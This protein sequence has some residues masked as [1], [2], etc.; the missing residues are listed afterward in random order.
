MRYTTLLLSVLLGCAS[1]AQEDDI[2]APAPGPVTVVEE[3][4]SEAA[5]APVEGFPSRPDLGHVLQRA[6]DVPLVVA[7]QAAVRRE[8]GGLRQ[9][10]LA[11][12][13]VLRM[14]V[15]QWD[16]DDLDGGPAR[17]WIRLHERFETGGK[18]GARKEVAEWRVREASANERWERFRVA[19]AAAAAH[20]EAAVYQERVRI[21]EQTL[22]TQ[23]ELVELK[24]AQVTSGREKE[25]VLIPLHAELG[26]LTVR[27]AQERAQVRAALRRLE[28]VLALPAGALDG[29]EGGLALI[30]RVLP[31]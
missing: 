28:G 1:S 21:G 7:A 25:A 31:A 14:S 13:P 29:V 18:R 4:T 9:A 10:G 6:A 30:E 12:N 24:T 2:P 5:P 23:Q 8:Q 26:E 20:Q 11:P 19:E 15:Q 22:K 3:S 27:L 16:F 17:R